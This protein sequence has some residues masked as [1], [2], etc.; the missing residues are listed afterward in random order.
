VD[1]QAA[2][3]VDL[4][5]IDESEQMITAD[6]YPITL[7]IVRPEGVKGKLPAFIFIH[8]GGLKKYLR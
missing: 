4:S 6:G 8:G 2:V 7:N 3:K 5:G 1:A